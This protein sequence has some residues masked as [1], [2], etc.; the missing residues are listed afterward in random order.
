MP[1]Q[2]S[3]VGRRLLP[4]VLDDIASSQPNRLYGSIARIADLNDG[5][6]DITFHDMSNGVNWFAHYLEDTIGQSNNFETIGYVGVSDFR[7]AIIFLAAVK[8]G[9][10]VRP[11]TLFYLS[12]SNDT[13]SSF[14]LHHEIPSRL[15]YH[16]LSKRDA[17]SFSIP[18]SS[19]RSSKPFKLVRETLIALRSPHSKIWLPGRQPTFRLMKPLRRQP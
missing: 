11:W 14:Y 12:W 19:H 15:T 2:K 6:R 1:S 9:Y 4:Q 18:L 7:T 8:C 16:C 13:R 3:N 17:G 5:F 10:K